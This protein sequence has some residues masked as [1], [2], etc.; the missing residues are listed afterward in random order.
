MKGDYKEQGPIRWRF[1]DYQVPHVELLPKPKTAISHQI[2]DPKQKACCYRVSSRGVSFQSPF[3][4]N[5]LS[6]CFLWLPFSCLSSRIFPRQTTIRGFCS[7]HIPFPS[8]SS[9]PLSTY[10]QIHTVD[11][12]THLPNPIKGYSQICQLSIVLEIEAPSGGSILDANCGNGSKHI[13]TIDG[14]HLILTLPQLEDQ[15]KRFPWPASRPIGLHF[16]TVPAVA[17]HWCVSGQIGRAR[18]QAF[19]FFAF[20]FLDV[21]S[22]RW[23]GGLVPDPTGSMKP[24][25]F[26]QPQE[27]FTPTQRIRRPVYRYGT[28]HSLP[29]TPPDLFLVVGTHS[30]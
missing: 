22:D 21:G 25:C 7:R 17:R 12:T 18:F 26:L 3:R 8:I 30:C 29:P 16:R 10:S 13:F 2:G 11:H 6:A 9:C 14:L 28:T 1:G 24:A 27:T 20:S 19:Q 15:T 4:T 23:V 5:R